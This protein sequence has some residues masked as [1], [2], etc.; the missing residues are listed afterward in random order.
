MAGLFISPNSPSLDQLTI[1]LLNFKNILFRNSIIR[2]DNRIKTWDGKNKI[3]QRWLY[4]R[5]IGYK[6]NNNLELNFM[7]AVIATGF[8]RGLEWYYLNPLS[9]LFMERKHQTIWTEGGDSTSVI[10]IGDND[11]HFIGGNIIFKIKPLQVYAELLIDEWQL[12]KSSRDNVQTIFGFLFGFNYNLDVVNIN[13]EYSLASPWLY[14]NRALYGGLEI[15]GLPIGLRNPHSQSIDLS[16]QFNFLID[17]KIIAQFHLEEKSEQNF[18]TYSDAWDIKVPLFN[19][20]NELPLQY[21]IH[22]INTKG[23]YFNKISIYKNWLG[24]DNLYYLMA[25]SWDINY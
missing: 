6:I 21:K 23:R 20:K 24:T 14:I 25:K 11:N 2:L 16:F 3:A 13:I 12:A 5:S 15:H 10:G 4:L 17:K 7:D 22:F 19:F 18:L 9:S 8:N 1:S